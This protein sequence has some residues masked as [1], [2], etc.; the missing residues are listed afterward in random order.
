MSCAGS[1]LLIA[2]AARNS[3]PLLLAAG[4]LAGGVS[5]LGAVTLFPDALAA[6][7]APPAR[8]APPCKLHT[9]Y[10]VYNADHVYGANPSVGSVY[11]RGKRKIGPDRSSS[12][13]EHMGDYCRG[14]AAHVIHSTLS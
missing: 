11:A 3:P 5:A 13:A 14:L 1:L 10:R 7:Y 9:V 8:T 12:H 4:A 2:A 6:R